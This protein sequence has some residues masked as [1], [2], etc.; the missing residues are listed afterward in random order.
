MQRAVDQVF[1]EVSLANLPVLFALDRAGA[2][3]EDGETHQ[4]IYDLALFKSMPNLTLFAPADSDELAAFMEY[5]LKLEGPSMMRYPKAF[6]PCPPE[7]IVP[8]EQ[9]KGVLIRRV[10]GAKVLALAVGPLASV[11]ASVADQ[12]LLRGIAVDV[13][14]MRFV[15]PLDEEYLANLCASYEGIVAFEDG[16]RVG[17]VGESVAAMLSQRGIRARF[18]SYGFDTIPYAQATREE[19]LAQAG[20]DE[21]GIFRALFAMCQNL[22]LTVLKPESPSAASIA[23]ASA[24]AQHVH[25]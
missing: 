6:S 24:E 16:V 18:A 15:A 19:L 23:S 10:P 25:S 7:N 1:Q 12:M 21:K 13:Y 5:A 8:L 4:G 14:N 20:L 3:G 2:V 9:G 11:A 22:G 17:G